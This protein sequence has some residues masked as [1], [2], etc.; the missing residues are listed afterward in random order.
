MG[1]APVIAILAEDQ[2]RWICDGHTTRAWFDAAQFRTE[3]IEWLLLELSSL[4]TITRRNMTNGFEVD[5][6]PVGDRSCS[7]DAICIR[8][9]SMNDGYF[10]H[11]VDGDYA[12]NGPEII[13]HI[14]RYYGNGKTV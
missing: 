12:G 4:N 13:K 3:V 9:G 6:L 7:G 2:V 10:V 8:Y 1:L 11:V 14:N 5:F